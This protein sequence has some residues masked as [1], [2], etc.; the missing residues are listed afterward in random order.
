M[1][2]DFEEVQ[3]KYRKHKIIEILN[4]YKP[5][6]ILEVGCGT[7]PLFIGYPNF[8]EYTVV[9]PSTEFYRSALAKA[10]GISNI[11]ILNAFFEQTL[12]ELNDTSF[13]FIIISAL[14]HEVEDPDALI[15]KA[16]QLC[17]SKTIVHANVPNAKSFHRLLALESG[18]IESIYQPS[19][20]NIRLQQNSV[21]D[22]ESFGT[23]FSRHGFH[24]L[25]AG[26]YFVKP[27]S[28]R[29]MLEMVDAGI[30]N[31]KILDGFYKMIKH[32]PEMG[33]EIFINCSLASDD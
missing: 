21:F 10:K 15:E 32:L 5:A 29:Q 6:R 25:D 26:S 30:V 17:N 31:D 18:L 23:L 27:F 24:I 16:A 14:L 28:H 11:R 20:N 33:S 12:S 1:Q 13:D 2:S 9:E 4:Q 3:V 22:S 7:E 8:S 19:E